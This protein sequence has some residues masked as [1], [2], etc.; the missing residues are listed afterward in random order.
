MNERSRKTMPLR[1]SLRA[2][3]FTL[4]TLISSVSLVVAVASWYEAKRANALNA[5]RLR[6]VLHPDHGADR[7]VGTPRCGYTVALPSTWRVLLYNNSAQP[8]TIERITY[9][10][11]SSFGVVIPISAD[12]GLS[13][14]GAKTPITIPAKGFE[15]FSAT[16][17]VNA[18]RAYAEWYRKMGF[19][20][21]KVFDIKNATKNAGFTETGGMTTKPSNAGVAVKVRTSDGYEVTAQAQ[22]DDPITISGPEVKIPANSN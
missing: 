19:C 10:G 8:V 12:V 15:S 13:T 21:T 3:A 16:I 9:I 14:I 5:E 7:A 20:D 17:E 1:V 22:W 18:P 2:F 6:I 4:P 11:F